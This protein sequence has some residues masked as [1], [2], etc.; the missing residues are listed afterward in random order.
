MT[1]RVST[2]ANGLRIVSEDMPQ[3]QTASVGVWVD[4]GVVI[5]AVYSVKVD[6]HVAIVVLVSVA[7]PA[8]LLLLP[9]LSEAAP[10]DA[11]PIIARAQSHSGRLS[12]LVQTCLPAGEAR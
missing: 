12:P 1:T 3:F 2:L 9:V 8:V 7:D 6:V 11:H 5:V 4:V 10:A